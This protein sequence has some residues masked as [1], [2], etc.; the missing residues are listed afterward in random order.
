MSPTPSQHLDHLWRRQA[1]PDGRRRWAARPAPIIKLG[2][3]GEHG[4]DAT[5]VEFCHKRRP[6]LCVLQPL[7]RASWPGLAAAQAAIKYPREH[8]EFVEIQQVVD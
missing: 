4:G 1:D 8:K 6:E 5:S 2:I 3:C 7:P